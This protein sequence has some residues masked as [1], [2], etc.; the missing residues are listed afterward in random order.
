M[1]DSKQDTKTAARRFFLAAALVALITPAEAGR[2]GCGS[3]GGA[4]YRKPN[5]KC[6]SKRG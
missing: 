5:G 1:K 3:R 6:A 4:G 2:R